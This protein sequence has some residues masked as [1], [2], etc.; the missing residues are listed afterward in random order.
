M[1][2]SPQRPKLV[3]IVGPTASGKSALAMQIAKKFSGEIIA[4]DSRTVIKGLDIGTAKPSAKER[5]EIP[6]WGLDLIEPGQNFSAAAFKQY[7]LEKI[8]E[9]SSRGRLPI[10]TGGTGL[11]VDSVLFDFQFGQSAKPKQRIQLE[12]LEIKT[13]QKMIV[14]KGLDMPQNRQNKRHLIR[15]IERGK[16]PVLKTLKPSKQAIIVGLWPENQILKDRISQRAEKM[17]GI[18]LQNEIQWL[19]RRYASVPPENLGLVYKLYSEVLS[20]TLD[21]KEALER[22]KTLEWQ[23]AK[24]QRTWFK[25]SPYIQW[26]DHPIK[27]KN[28]L[29]NKLNT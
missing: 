23:Y 24:R 22:Y 27:A 2:S 15:T 7:A 6:H 25:R 11:Y 19:T 13:L 3:V 26:F 14:E 1:A 21:D 12:K 8:T 29:E 28:Y 10:L 9:I 5:K 17:F 4:A 16:S 18:G 20:G